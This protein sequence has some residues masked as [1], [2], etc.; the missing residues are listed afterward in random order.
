MAVPAIGFEVCFRGFREEISLVYG[1][2]VEDYKG[3][4]CNP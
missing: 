1:F 2:E 3:N 4:G